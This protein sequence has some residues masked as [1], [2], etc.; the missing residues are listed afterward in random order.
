MKNRCLL[1]L[2]ATVWFPIHASAQPTTVASEWQKHAKFCP[3]SAR[4]YGSYGGTKNYDVTLCYSHG[5]DSYYIG[6]SKATGRSIIVRS[7]DG[8]FLNSEHEYKVTFYSFDQCTLQVLRN[9]RVLVSELM[10]FHMF[11]TPPCIYQ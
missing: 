4:D 6:R 3:V 2:F 7:T 1:V 5:G 10:N 8:R 11:M 9:N